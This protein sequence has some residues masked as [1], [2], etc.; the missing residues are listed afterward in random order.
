[1]YMLARFGRVVELLAAGFIGA[2]FASFIA[3]AWTGPASSPPN[4]NVAAP[5]N[6]GTVDQVKNSGLSVN[7]LAVFGNTLLSGASRYLNFGTIPG[8]EGYGIRD[9]AGTMEFKDAAGDW[10][11]ISGGAETD[12]QV[13]ALTNGRWCTTDGTTVNCTSTAPSGGISAATTASCNGGFTGCT[14]SCPSSYYRTGCV[15]AGNNTTNPDPYGSNGCTVNT[16]G[17]I[18]FCA[19]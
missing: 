2:I 3:I 5:I 9:N 1:M 12:P 6:V 13:G 16:G 18:I 10:A 17:V 11:G 7:A 15:Q 14:V 4:S 19:R 8:D